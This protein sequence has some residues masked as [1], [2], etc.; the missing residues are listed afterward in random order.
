MTPCISTQEV[1]KLEVR[2]HS[3]LSAAYQT[4][5]RHMLNNCVTDIHFHKKL[6]SHI[7]RI[8]PIYGEKIS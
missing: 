8:Y 1:L 4:T 2:Y 7:G 6:K 5:E 3:K